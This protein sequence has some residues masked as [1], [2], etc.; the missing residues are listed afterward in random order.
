MLRSCQAP[1]LSENLAGGS[2]PPLPSR[3]GSAQYAIYYCYL[4]KVR[5]VLFLS[6]TQTSFWSVNCTS[7][8]CKLYLLFQTILDLWSVLILEIFSREILRTGSFSIL[9][10]VTFT[11][12][13]SGFQIEHIR[14]I[15]HKILDI[16]IFLSEDF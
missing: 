7:L 5:F 1:P 10:L 16:G 9:T 8:V 2:T 4:W 15:Y 12:A 11:V 3:K 14:S 13:S 6:I